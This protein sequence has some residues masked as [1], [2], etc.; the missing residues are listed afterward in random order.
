MEVL[1]TIL[2][3]LNNPMLL[4]P[5]QLGLGWVWKKAPNVPTKLIPIF[6]LGVAILARV[7]EVA[8]GVP[9]E[10]S[11]AAFA[12]YVV[13]AGAS[14]FWH[15]ALDVVVSAVGQTLVT[16]GTHSTFKNLIQMFW[17]SAA[18]KVT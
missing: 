13:A 11:G 15:T 10:N 16:T 14:S 4:M 9:V 1:Q 3:L 18:K 17:I 5:I 6:N 2:T 12:G 8:A 7:G